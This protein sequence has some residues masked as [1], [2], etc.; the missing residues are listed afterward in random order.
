MR[1]GITGWWA[2][3]G[4]SCTSPKKRKQLELYYID[5]YSLI[6]DIKIIFKTIIAVIK[7][8]GAK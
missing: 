4:R 8:E 3:N 5:N 6:L 1:P 2:C 7:K